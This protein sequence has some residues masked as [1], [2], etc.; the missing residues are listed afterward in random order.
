MIIKSIRVKNFRSILDET[1]PCEQLTVLVGANGAG[2][3]SFLRALELFYATSPKFSAED[4]YVED[5]SQDIEIT[6]TFMDLDIEEAERFASYLENGGLTVVRVL[7]IADG[8]TS[9][10]YHGSTLQHPVF[11][12][13]RQAGGAQ[14]IRAKYGEI[15]GKPEYTSLP[16]VG[17]KDAALEELRKWEIAHPD[18]CTRQRDDGQFFGFTE[19]AQGYLGRD[20]RFIPI[21]AVRDAAD[22]AVEGK[23]SPITEIM[24][25]VVRSVLVNREDVAQLKKDAQKRYEEIMDP[26]KLA[27]IGTLAGRLTSTLKLYVPD[28]SVSLSW[29][30]AGSIEIPMPKADVHLVEDGYP[31]TVVRTGHGLQRAFIITMLQHLA[32]VHAPTERRPRGEDADQGVRG[33]GPATE[34]RMPNLI[35][36]I[37]EPELYQHPNRQRHL[38]IFA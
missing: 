23:G 24:D 9:A 6:V 26:A 15:R 21:H 25:L 36:G 11:D 12:E 31:S 22:D 37:E 17:T 7:S 4:F 13:V 29:N 30:K 38:L 19:V 2:K 18:Q 20:T 1:L 3:S 16:P 5:T 10:K 27:E 8:K 32:V 33:G 35:L 34:P 14:Q 28:A